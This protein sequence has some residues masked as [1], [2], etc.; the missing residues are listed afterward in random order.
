MK[1]NKYIYKFN[2]IY[3]VIS[4]NMWDVYKFLLAYII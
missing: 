3:A 4:E 1:Y 2:D